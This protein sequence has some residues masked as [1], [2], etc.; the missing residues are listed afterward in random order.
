[1][2]DRV[3]VLDLNHTAR[4]RGGERSLLSLIAGLPDDVSAVVGCPPGPLAEATREL[5]LPVAYVP[6][7]DASLKLHPWHTTRGLLDIAR[8][9]WFVRRLAATLDADLVHA[10]SIRAGIAATCAASVGG[11]P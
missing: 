4:M 2:H 11:P 6:G 8:A 1:P 10:N 3:R 9:T 5:G 7:T